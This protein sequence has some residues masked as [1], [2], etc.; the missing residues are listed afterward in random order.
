MVTSSTLVER[1]LFYTGNTIQEQASVVLRLAPTFMRFGSFEICKTREESNTDRSGPS[2][3]QHLLLPKMVDFVIFYHYA[4]IWKAHGGGAAMTDGP[5]DKKVMY[6]AFLSE[7][8]TRTARL[9]AGWQSVGF[10][11]GVRLTT[12]PANILD[13]L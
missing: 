5:P 6:T 9:V 12:I 3:G 4:D 1:D 13:R 10:C 7:V 11:H 8:V 2:A